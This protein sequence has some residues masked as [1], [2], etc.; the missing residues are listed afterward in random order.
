MWG[1]ILHHLDTFTIDKKNEYYLFW[2]IIAGVFLNLI[3]VMVMYPLWEFVLKGITG[4]H[5]GQN[6]FVTYFLIVGP[7][8]ET[9]KFLV[10]IFLAGIFKSIKEPRDGLIQAGSAALGFSLIENFGYAMAY[11]LSVLLIRS[12]ITTLG[13]VTFAA[14]WG[15]GWGA[16]QYSS[17]SG[18][19][20]T[21]R[22][23]VIPLLIAAMVVHA[24]FD[25]L[26]EYGHFYLALFLDLADLYIF[27][28][29]YR[30]VKN[31]R[32]QYPRVNP[33]LRPLSRPIPRQSRG[34]FQP[35]V[36]CTRLGQKPTSCSAPLTP[37][38][39]NSPYRRYTLREYKKA[40][41]VLEAGL[42]RH[43]DSYVLNK[44]MGIFKMYVRRYREAQKNLKTA[45]KI[46]SR[47]LEARYFPG[48]SMFLPGDT[49]KGLKMM[50]SV[51]SRMPEVPRKKLNRKL[52][53]IISSTPDREKIYSRYCASAGKFTEHRYLAEREYAGLNRALQRRGS[54][55]I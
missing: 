20:T 12:V 44:R 28:M 51:V 1:E 2:F 6:P 4:L 26:L 25:T 49:E 19:K 18:E 11:G 31:E 48:A 16:Y 9:T 52:K 3:L 47:G 15:L 40:I 7:V 50:N 17:G 42:K 55:D 23:F 43:K 46:N 38:E 24:G 21:D 41:P 30:F 32:F 29:F 36:L 45:V 34:V 37:F 10:F 13:H 54:S 22:F 14:F 35:S 53:K 5:D 27:I 39:N 33:G 8:E